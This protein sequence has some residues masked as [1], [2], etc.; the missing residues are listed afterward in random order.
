MIEFHCSSCHRAFAVKNHLAGRRAKCKFCGEMLTVPD[1]KS[2]PRVK[3]RATAPP[4]MR[5]RRLMAD[6]QQMRKAFASSEFIR[7]HAREGD[8]PDT[9]KI[10]YRIASLARDSKGKPVSRQEHEVEIHLTHDYPRLSPMCRM[11]TPIFHPNIDSSTICVGD[12]WTAGE[13]LADLVVRIGE[14]LA[15]QA[16]N[17]KS[18]LDGE[19][20]MWADLNQEK[21]PTDSRNLRPRE[22]D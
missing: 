9:Y 16:Y 11:L 19:A 20:A 21:L 7:V 12:H 3:P 18:P 1:P 15:Y 10:E 2:A 14:M 6:A 5:I 4:P 13:R 8:P 22:M 17:I